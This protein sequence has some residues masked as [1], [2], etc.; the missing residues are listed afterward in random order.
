MELVVQETE[1]EIESRFVLKILQCD[2]HYDC[3]TRN[4]SDF[5]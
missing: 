4:Y 1:G 2:Y 5:L 3:I